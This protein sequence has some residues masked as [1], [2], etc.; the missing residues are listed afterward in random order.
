[1]LCVVLLWCSCLS[2]IVGGKLFVHPHLSSTANMLPNLVHCV[3]VV[4]MSVMWCCVQI[5]RH[6]TLRP[7]VESPSVAGTQTLD[8]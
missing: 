4:W 7:H 6:S 1:M 2:P 3:V 8:G 5:E